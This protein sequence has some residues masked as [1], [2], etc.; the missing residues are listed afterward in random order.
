MKALASLLEE[1]RA[2]TKAHALDM[3]SMASEIRVEIAKID[4]ELRALQHPRKADRP[5]CGA[6]TRDGSRCAAPAA[7]GGDRCR[8]HGGG[9]FDGVSIGRILLQNRRK[10]LERYLRIAEALAGQ[11]KRKFHW[12]LPEG[13]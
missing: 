13:R 10:E 11:S 1:Y 2:A 6:R 5:K 4:S 12:K 9:G 8:V 3:K 7:P